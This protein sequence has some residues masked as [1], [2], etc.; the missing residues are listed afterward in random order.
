MGIG[1]IFKNPFQAAKDVVTLGNS[2]RQAKREEATAQRVSDAYMSQV[3]N[4]QNHIATANNAIIQYAQDMKAQMS[5]N[6]EKKKSQMNKSIIRNNR[7]PLFGG[8]DNG[9]FKDTL[10]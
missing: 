10:G 3:Q 8:D 2:S 5:S 4:M 1:K 6:L 9:M 7:R